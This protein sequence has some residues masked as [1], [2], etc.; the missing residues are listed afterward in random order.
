MLISP[1]TA[2]RQD[3]ESMTI[4]LLTR[5]RRAVA[6]LSCALIQGLALAVSRLVPP[7][8]SPNSPLCFDAAQCHWSTVSCGDGVAPLQGLEAGCSL[9]VYDRQPASRSPGVCGA[10]VSESTLHTDRS[11]CARSVVVRLSWRIARLV[12]GGDG[13]LGRRHSGS[14]VPWALGATQRS[15]LRRRFVTSANVQDP[16]GCAGAVL[17]QVYQGVG[18]AAVRDSARRLQAHF[19]IAWR[20]R[21]VGALQATLLEDAAAVSRLAAS[22]CAELDFKNE[23]LDRGFAVTRQP[24]WSG[25]FREV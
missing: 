9:G 12:T 6:Q 20:T 13:R 7:D 1:W 18:L 3:I 8:R 25:A 16:G 14:M 11:N 10:R 17:A 2:R 22:V 19:G 4:G 15:C 5:C 24:L 23:G 21:T